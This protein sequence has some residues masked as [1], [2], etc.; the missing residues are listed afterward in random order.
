MTTFVDGDRP[1][2]KYTCR[3]NSDKSVIDLTGYTSAKLYYRIEG[4]DLQTKTMTFLSPR[5]NGQVEY[6]F[7]LGELVPG[8]FHGEIEIIDAAGRTFR[9]EPAIHFPVR[10]KV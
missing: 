8:R 9:Q 7:L 2:L 6:Q 4:G 10:S 5:T 3:K 1:L